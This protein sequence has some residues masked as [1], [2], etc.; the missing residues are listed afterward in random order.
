[1]R[2]LRARLNLRGPALTDAEWIRYAYALCRERGMTEA[3][4]QMAVAQG[5]A[6]SW[7]GVR[8][9]FLLADGS[10]SFNW[11]ATTAK[12]G[13][14]YFTGGDKN[15]SGAP[16]VQRWARWPSMAEGLD[17]W[18]SF[19]SVRAGLGAM[20][21]GDA[22]LYAA[23]LFDRGYYTGVNC[24]RAECVR[25]Y[26]SWLE[27]TTRNK[28]APALGVPSLVNKGGDIPSSTGGIKQGTLPNRAKTGVGPIAIAFALGGLYLVRKVIS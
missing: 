24:A 23:I 12:A 8:K 26:A 15:A 7:L 21:E 25:A 14:P 27:G 19:G 28:I 6:E 2:P 13:V 17:Y 4:A 3:G 20:Q 11:G 5:W 22:V 1:M 18:L 9:P 16:I 10:P